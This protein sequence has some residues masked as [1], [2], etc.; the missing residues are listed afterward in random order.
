MSNFQIIMALLRYGLDL[1]FYL[2]LIGL[3]GFC[4]YVVF[5][6][7]LDRYVKDGSS[8]VAHTNKRGRNDGI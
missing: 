4:L 3:T 1:L 5:I 2:I 7:V 8:R 6:R